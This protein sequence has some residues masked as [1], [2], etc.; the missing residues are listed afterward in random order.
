MPKQYFPVKMKDV[1]IVDRNLSKDQIHYQNIQEI[2]G[3]YSSGEQTA[4]TITEH[5]LK[6]IEVLDPT[7]LSYAT[8]MGNEALKQ[9]EILSEEWSRNHIRGP[10]HGIPIAVKDL[11]YTKGIR[12]MG[13]TAVLEENIPNH[14]ATVVSK[15]RSAG[16]VILGKLN[17]TEGAMGGYNPRRA[18]PKNPWNTKKWT[19]SS[20]SG[21]GVSTAAGFC[22]GSLGSDTG[23]SIRFPSA[24]CGLVG[25]KP[26]YGR[27]SR[28]GVL[29]LGQTLDHVGPMTRDVRDAAL[30]LQA[31]SGFDVNDLTTL[32]VVP[33]HFED[34][35]KTDLNG[36]IIGYS[37]VYSEE[38]VDKEVVKAVHDAADILRYH[39]ATIKNIDLEGIDAFLPAWKTICTAEAYNAHSEFFPERSEEYGLWFR[40]W[41]QHGTSVSAQDYIDAS[42][43]RELCNGRIREAFNGITAMLSPTV[44][45]PPHDVDDSI[46]YG[47]MD[48]RRGTSFQRFTVPFDYNGYPT[49]SVPAG[50]NDDALPLSIQISG[51]PLSEELLCRIA[52]TYEKSLNLIDFHPFE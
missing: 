38:G 29:D 39:G 30:I 48:D 35:E 8:V 45:R 5:F 16:A 11:C 43:E 41:L 23:G 10:L 3:S 2:T 1:G 40:G 47:P 31:L 42:R 18:V 36:V 52:R 26:T 7:Y 20:S 44:I 34:I 28:Y 32:P 37:E 50:L 27:V 9:A 51:H 15:L 13:G 46:S 21:S 19:G 33:P 49:V 14:D 24:A 17:L 6:R 4:S 22:T 25:I 12:T